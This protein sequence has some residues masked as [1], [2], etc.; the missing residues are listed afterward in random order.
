MTV[1]TDNSEQVLISGGGIGGLAAALGIAKAGYRVT[2]LEQADSF[3]E[4]GAGIQ[5]GPNAFRALDRLG[6]GQRARDNAVLIDALVLMDGLSGQEVTRIPV[7]DAFRQRFGAPYAVAH[8]ADMHLSLLEGCQQNPDVT[9]LN[10]QRVTD[11]KQDEYGVT[12][13]TTSGDE[14]RGA[15]LIGCDGLKSPIREKIVGDGAPRVSGHIT[16]RAV[17]PIEQMPEDLRWNAATLW[18]GPKYHLVHYPL[19]GWELFNI[20]A[21]FHS[22]RTTEGAGEEGSRE[23]ILE[24]FSSLV[25]KARRI[26]ETPESWKLWV[27]CDREPVDNWT[28]GRVTLL[29]DAAHPTLQYFAQ[30]ACMAIEDAVCLADKLAEHPEALQ[31]AFVD[32][33]NDRMARTARIQLQSRL[34]G[35]Y[36]YHPDGARRQLRNAVM[37]AKR[38][39]DYYSDLQWLYGGGPGNSASEPWRL[40]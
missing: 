9:L 37:A 17:L 10:R 22:D 4:I 27:L 36:I 28:D 2:V 31:A 20:V 19:R 5:M 13:Y 33:Q 26:L 38:P 32:Y 30:G 15:A 3:G 7:K 21:T 29:G 24:R 23:E 25:P 8:R 11:Y 35:D 40:T 16:Y 6:V 1:H 34:I 14:F 12:V 39:E 18:A